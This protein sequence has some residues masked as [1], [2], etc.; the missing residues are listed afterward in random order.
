MLARGTEM[1]RAR[2]AAAVWGEGLGSVWV[3]F[4]ASSAR[5]DSLALAQL[6]AALPSARRAACLPHPCSPGEPG[7]P[8]L[9]PACDGRR[10]EP[11][12]PGRMVRRRLADTGPC[13]GT[14]NLKTLLIKK[15][16]ES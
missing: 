15:N 9:G 10:S 14:G 5:Q 1:S 3:C 2:G 12:P 4:P 11:S 7:P 6:P 16:L 8:P 13:G